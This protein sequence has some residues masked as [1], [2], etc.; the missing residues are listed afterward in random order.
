MKAMHLDKT[1]TSDERKGIRFSCWS[2]DIFCRWDKSNPCK[3]FFSCH[4]FWI[5]YL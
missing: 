2:G 1:I 4:F 5:L 3:S